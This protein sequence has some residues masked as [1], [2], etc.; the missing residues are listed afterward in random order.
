MSWY[1]EILVTESWK[2]H[3]H[4][5]K[6]WR[7]MRQSGATKPYSWALEKEAEAAM[8]IYYPAEI[9][10]ETVRVVHD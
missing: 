7:K 4:Q 1:V 3:G 8:R 5:E 2:Y 9:V 10:G 6:V